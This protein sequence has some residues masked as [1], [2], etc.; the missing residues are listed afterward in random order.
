MMHSYSSIYNLGHRALASLLDNEVLVEEKVDGS[1]FSFHK[2]LD[3]EI[4][5]RSRGREIFPPIEDKL[6]KGAV[7]Y[8][9]SIG[10]KL[11]IGYIYRGEVLSKPKHNTIAYERVPRHNIVIFDIDLGDQHYISHE[12]KV[13]LAEELDLEVVPRMFEGKV[14]N[15]EQLKGFMSYTSFL[16]TAT[17]EGIVIK[18]YSQFGPNKKT[19]MGKWVSEAFKEKHNSEWKKSNLTQTTVVES[20]IEEYRHEGRWQKAVQHLSEAGTLLNEPKDIGSLMKEIGKDILKEEEEN[21]K[22]ALWKWAWPKIQRGA[23]RGMPEWYKNK[24]AERQ[25]EKESV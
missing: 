22:E 23:T 18:N 11:R 16:G 20:L 25:F 19:L 2:T 3:R 13:K 1:Q 15:I 24:L 5:F 4:K 14:T 17:V 9:L 7:E 8:I 21:I 10:Y 12:Q 6:F